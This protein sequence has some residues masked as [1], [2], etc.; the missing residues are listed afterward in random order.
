MAVISMFYGLVIYLYFGDD[1]R[2]H[3][4]HIHVKYQ[5]EDT[6]FSIPD[7][8]LLEG[9]LKT[10]KKKLI[11]AWMVIHAEELLANWDLAV[12]GQGIF[13]IDPLK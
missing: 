3:T 9:K 8:K 5:G 1:K 4:P 10:N 7:G 11:Q 12:S 6:V 13:K 2:H